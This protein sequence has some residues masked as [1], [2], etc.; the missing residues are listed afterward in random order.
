MD[1]PPKVPGSEGANATTK[2][3]KRRF[4]GRRTAEAQTSRK[5]DETASVEE[6]SVITQR[7]GL[8]EI[9]KK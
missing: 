8:L 9:P 3:P 4:V 6:T 5:H 1:T 2:Q 7:G